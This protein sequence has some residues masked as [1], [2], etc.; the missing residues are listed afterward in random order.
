MS[1]GGWTFAPVKHRELP[2][3]TLTKKQLAENESAKI[4]HQKKCA[5]IDALMDEATKKIEALGGEVRTDDYD[6]T[7][8]PEL[9]LPHD[10]DAYDA[11]KFTDED[12]AYYGF[13]MQSRWEEP[14]KATIKKA[15]EAGLMMGWKFSG[16][17]AGRWP[18]PG[19][20]YP[21]IPEWI[22]PK[23]MKQVKSNPK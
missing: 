19:S 4:A 21:P 11:R 18:I 8:H 14:N 3:V 6:N 22:E 12:H 15:L 9:V 23:Y 16:M 20:E 10:P 1:W 2:R 13:L 7:F 17:S 5:E